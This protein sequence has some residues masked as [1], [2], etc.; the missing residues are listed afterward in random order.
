M[1]KNLVKELRK[2]AALKVK[3]WKQKEKRDKRKKEE[4]KELSEKSDDEK[5]VL[6]GYDLGPK[7]DDEDEPKEKKMKQS[8][9]NKLQQSLQ[10]D[11]M[12]KSTTEKGFAKMPKQENKK[13]KV[14]MQKLD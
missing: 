5:S 7:S 9:L 1:P 13:D 12:L 3:L 10:V 4:G 11:R 8:S 6:H 2:K 14:Y